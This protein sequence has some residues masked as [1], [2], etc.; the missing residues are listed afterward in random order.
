[1]SSMEIIKDGE[2]GIIIHKQ[3]ED[4]SGDFMRLHQVQK[5]LLLMKLLED[6]GISWEASIAAKTWVRTEGC[7]E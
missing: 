6:K 4:S 5:D 3:Y 2:G 7:H 1:M